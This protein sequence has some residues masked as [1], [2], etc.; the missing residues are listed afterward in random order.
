MK[1]L[2]SLNQK[3]K[4]E[5]K[6]ALI[7]DENEVYFSEIYNSNSDHLNEIQEGEVVALIGDFNASSISNLLRLID[8]KCIVVPL[9]PM[10]SDEHEYYFEMAEV[11]WK[12]ENNNIT[13]LRKGN[14]SNLL[15]ELQQDHNPGLI[16]F[17]SG[18]TGRPKAILH[19]MQN[20]LKRFET[21]RPTLK[22]LAFLLFDHIGGINTLLH[23]LYNVGTIICTSDRS[24]TNVLRICDKHEIEVLPTTPTFLR[25]L[26]IS[27]KIPSEI[28]N[29]LKIITYGTE[30]MDEGTLKLLCALLPE[31]DF[32][33][34]FGMS[35]LGILRVK[36]KSRDSLYMKIGGEGIEW[37]VEGG[38][39]L[40]KSQNR[41]MGYLN[42]S[43]PFD[44]EGWYQ[45]NDLV[46]V[47]GEY[48]KVVGR[49]ND[50]A[51][52]GGLK[53]LLTEVERVIYEIPEIEFVTVKAKNNPITGQHIEADIQINKSSTLD[54]SEIRKILMHRL[55]NH[56]IPR[57]I[58]LTT[59][60]IGHRFKKI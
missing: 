16:L 48:I 47:D 21:P 41:M 28:P 7:I 11:N 19:N 10:T 30:R 18:T 27:G 4:Y 39:L 6:P 57:R 5:K 22:T 2:E 53:F 58:N 9:S 33:Q 36:S 12:V 43:S 24:V 25:M 60:N 17:S 29:S 51:N 20:F 56:M 32:R 52:I 26:L 54:E 15:L 49:K 42:S 40:I 13:R 55:A 35:E 46:E 44:G 50:I 38:S 37:K 3:W 14:C 31:V 59:V 1:I 23:T 45:T 34:T 8:K